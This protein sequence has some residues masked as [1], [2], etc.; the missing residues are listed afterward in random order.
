[1]DSFDDS[2]AEADEADESDSSA[3]TVTDV[4]DYSGPFH[5]VNITD[6]A[7]RTYK[8]VLCWIATGYIR[9]APLTSTFVETDTASRYTQRLAAVTQAV[10]DSPALPVPASPKSVFRLADYF[11]LPELCKLALEAIE[12][13]LSVSNAANE[14][15]SDV[16]GAYAEVRKV[17][18]EYT[19]QHY[20]EV[21]GT[22]GWKRAEARIE[23]GEL[24]VS[25]TLLELTRQLHA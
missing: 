19:M 16:A 22:E 15:F 11:E 2:D 7:F 13:E 1:M 12:N 25:Q 14:L 18:L 24:E 8:A 3:N 9:L 5:Q 21:K 6:A 23:A 20:D 4:V 10:K 17:V